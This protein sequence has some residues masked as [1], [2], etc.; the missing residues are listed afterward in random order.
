[1]NWVEDVISEGEEELEKLN[2]AAKN[3][4]IDLHIPSELLG[5]EDEDEAN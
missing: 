5:N 1:M 2:N 3:I 4:G